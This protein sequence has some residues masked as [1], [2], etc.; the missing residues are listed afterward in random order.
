VIWG[1]LHGLYLAINHAWRFL[2]AALAKRTTVNVPTALR[3]AGR[4]LA[5]TLTLFSTV[6]AWVFFRAHS[7]TDALRI[8]GSM[9]AVTAAVPL[10]APDVGLARL[11]AL[12]G[13]FALALSAKNSQ[14]LIDGSFTS[15]VQRIAASGWR[16]IVLAAIVGAEITAIALVALISASRSVTEFIY[17]N[18]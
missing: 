17:F 1:G 16:V 7:E 5:V 6:V 2:C 15:A 13:G 4:T 12:V 18:F 11:A 10:S 3:I 9:F 8:L 14:Q